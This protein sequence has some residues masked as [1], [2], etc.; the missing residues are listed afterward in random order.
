MK[1]FT[2][3]TVGGKRRGGSEAEVGSAQG[4]P[5]LTKVGEKY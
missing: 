5:A 4:E 2:S 1:L 3:V